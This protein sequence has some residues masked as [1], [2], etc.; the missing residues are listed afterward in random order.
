MRRFDWTQVS[1]WHRDIRWWKHDGSAFKSSPRVPWRPPNCGKICKRKRREITGAAPPRAAL[2]WMLSSFDHPQR[3]GATSRFG[4]R[5]SSRFCSFSLYR[6]CFPSPVIFPSHLLPYFFL[7]VSLPLYPPESIID[8]CF[9]KASFKDMP[10]TRWVHIIKNPPARCAAAEIEHGGGYHT[11]NSYNGKFCQHANYTLYRKKFPLDRK[12][13]SKAWRCLFVHFVTHKVLK[14][15]GNENAQ[16]AYLVSSDSGKYC[17]R[18]ILS[19]VLAWGE[20]NNN[21][22]ITNDNNNDL[23]NVKRVS[24]YP[25]VD[26]SSTLCVWEWVSLTNRLSQSLPV[27][28][29]HEEI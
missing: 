29:P 3:P 21:I 26:S 24:A 10:E 11:D 7:T 13:L 16:S 4:M 19:K 18:Q 27:R 28:V 14:F 1:E 22:I 9:C 25:T 5:H 20:D 8:L 2:T 23:Q 6:F 17:Q 15:G 12:V